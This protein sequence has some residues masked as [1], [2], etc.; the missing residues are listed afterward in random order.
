MRNNKGQLGLGTVKTVFI[1]FLI[2]A[3]IAVTIILAM[4]SLRD[5]TDKVDRQSVRIDNITS[6]GVVNETGSPITGTVGFRN[7]DLTV[8]QVYNQTNGTA[9]LASGNYSVSE[10]T[11][12]GVRGCIIN[13]AGEAGEEWESNNTVWNVTGSYTY[14]DPATTNILGNISDASVSFFTNTGT[15]LAILV[16]V[17]I[18]L[19]IAIIIAVVTRFGGEG[20]GP[21][22]G[23]GRMGAFGLGGKKEFGSETVAG[24]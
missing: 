23:E 1:A 24:V 14:S 5:V 15:I 19:A 8:L 22:G 2:L 17:V 12:L 13:F 16:V 9:P 11:D 18:I 4:N 6:L 10:F 7:C 3:V 20:G 21:S